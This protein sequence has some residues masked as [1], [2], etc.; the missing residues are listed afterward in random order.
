MSWRC[1]ALAR[2]C[3]SPG[4]GE[5]RLPACPP[6]D[7][8]A[9]AL[10]PASRPAAAAAHPPGSAS[11]ALPLPQRRAAGGGGGWRPSDLHIDAA[12]RLTA[13]SR[14]APAQA[15]VPAALLGQQP[16]SCRCSLRSSLLLAAA[17]V[18]SRS[19][20][21]LLADHFSVTLRHMGR[22][23]STTL[24]ARP[25]RLVPPRLPRR[26]AHVCR[27]LQVPPRQDERRHRLL[28]LQT[29]AKHL[30][31]LLARVGCRGKGWAAAARARRDGWPGGVG[32]GGLRPRAPPPPARCPPAASP[33]LLEAPAA[34]ISPSP[35][36][37][38]G[39]APARAR[40][41]FGGVL[42]RLGPHHRQR[43]RRLL[44]AVPL[45]RVAAQQQLIRVLVLAG[46]ATGGE[47]GEPSSEPQQ[48]ARVLELCWQGCG[49]DASCVSGT[50]RQSRCRPP[51]RTAAQPRPRTCGPVS[52]PLL[53]PPLPPPLLLEAARSSTSFFSRVRSRGSL[54]PGAGCPGGGGGAA[55]PAP[56]ACPPSPGGCGGACTCGG[57]S[58]V[59]RRVGRQVS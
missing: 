1:G 58:R 16:V 8:P 56:A 37:R 54:L 4:S 31:Q 48:L 34:T 38:S 29:R 46:E 53:P 27:L 47:E 25:L 57:G 33:P 39:H 52:C 10:Q 36:Q 7:L 9:W 2:E 59:Q 3:R 42:V 18:L 40:T 51:P 24:A 55:P 19:A 43:Q 41:D 26:Q 14:Q 20:F 49:V 11:L 32:G 45:G 28:A 44:P 21:P 5:P 15:R 6:A 17:A 35:A 50:A 23:A 22:R 30:A 13:A 12:R